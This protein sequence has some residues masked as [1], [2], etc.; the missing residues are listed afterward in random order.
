MKRY[1]RSINRILI[2]QP[3][4]NVPL[5][6]VVVHVTQSDDILLEW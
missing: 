6:L 4:C 5:Q 1:E 2:L 3:C